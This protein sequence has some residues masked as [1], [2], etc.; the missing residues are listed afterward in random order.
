MDAKPNPPVK[1]LI[2]LFLLCGLLSGCSGTKKTTADHARDTAALE[3]IF[4]T[5]ESDRVTGLRNQDWCQVLGYKRGMFCHSTQGNRPHPATRDAVA[6]DAT[7]RLDLERIWKT[8]NGSDVEIL[9][10]SDIEFDASGHLK[11]G[12]FDCSEGFVRQRYVFHPGYTL[13][14]DMPN[15]QWHTRVDSDWYY[16]LEDWN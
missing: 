3:S 10:I 5:L 15:Q 9:L 11:R 13:P 16:V 2:R 1:K 8:V 14:A 12:E 4:P 7:A 6:F